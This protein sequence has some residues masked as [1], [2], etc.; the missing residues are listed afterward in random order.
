MKLWNIVQLTFKYLNLSIKF[1]IPF[2]Q[3]LSIE[4]S[5]GRPFYLIIYECFKDVSQSTHL[6][7]SPSRNVGRLT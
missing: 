7:L 4:V 3:L 5:F 6:F 2:H 1:L